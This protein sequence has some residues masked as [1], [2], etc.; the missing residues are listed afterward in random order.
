MNNIKILCFNKIVVSEGVD[1]NKTSKSKECNICHYK[2][3]VCNRCLD[4]LMKSM[5]L[6]N[7]AV[8]KF[9][10]ADY[11]CIITGISKNEALMLLQNIDLTRKVWTILKLNIKSKFEARNLPQILI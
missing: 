2:T 1:V 9:K 4:L 11:L 5:N 10:N 7:T 8:L 3:Y 6:S